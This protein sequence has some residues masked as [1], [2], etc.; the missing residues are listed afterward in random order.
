VALKDL[1]HL[2]NGYPLIL[3]RYLALDENADD[4]LTRTATGASGLFDQDV[5]AARSLNEFG[6]LAADGIGTGRVLASG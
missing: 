6:K 2:G 1:L 5:A 4:G 3:E